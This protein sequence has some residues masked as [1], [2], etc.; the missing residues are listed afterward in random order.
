[1]GRL[2]L[3]ATAIRPEMA[4]FS[5]PS[6]SSADSPSV[7]RFKASA[8][9]GA[10]FGILFE[11]EQIP[12]A[13]E[14]EFVEEM[15][16][17]DELEV[18]TERLLATTLSTA[19][20]PMAGSPALLKEERPLQVRM[21][22]RSSAGWLAFMNTAGWRR[23][24]GPCFGL[25][26]LGWVASAQPFTLT[27]P[28]YP[29]ATSVGVRYRAFNRPAEQEVYVGSNLGSGAGRNAA[30]FTYLSG[31][32][33]N[34][35]SIT[36]NATAPTPA[37]TTVIRG[38]TTS[39]NVSSPIPDLRIGLYSGSINGSTTATVSL[40]NLVLNGSPVGGG[41]ISV[42]ST[43]PTQVGRTWGLSGFDFTQSFTLTGD[44]QLTPLS[45]F[46]TSAETSKVEFLFGAQVPEAST[47]GAAGFVV[48][49]VAFQIIRRR[50]TDV[51]AP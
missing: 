2:T 12:V 25:V 13:P 11:S 18:P 24:V 48:S 38:T 8:I 31:A 23:K 49:L 30:N 9:K 6:A 16:N 45:T 21:D 7:S 42:T 37:I 40:I 22:G 43:S 32:S 33:L 19:S 27:T 20:G 46:S 26:A 34:S 4:L 50:R 17:D 14:G 36:Y 29:V 41:P 28:P 1:M 5:A 3:R 44:L 15:G 10:K 47:W 51:V 35:F 39:W